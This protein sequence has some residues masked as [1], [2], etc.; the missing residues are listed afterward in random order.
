MARPFQI[1]SY[2][3]LANSYVN[4]QWYPFTDPE[5]LK[6]E[7]R[8]AALNRKIES[9]GADIICLQEVESDAYALFEY[10]LRKEGYSGIYAPKANNRPDGCATFFRQGNLRF[11]GSNTIYFNDTEEAANSGHVALILSFASGLG[12]LRVT[13]THLKWDNETKPKE[14]HAGYRQIKE[15]VDNHIKPD[16]LAHAWIVC[17]DF[18]AQ[19]GSPVIEKLLVNGFEDAYRGNEQNTCNSNRRAK[20]IDYIFHTGNLRSQPAKLRVIDNLTPLPSEVEPSDHLAIMAV[21]S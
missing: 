14:E 4:P 12:T 18:N 13:N 17:G 11:E 8:K 1:A 2:N 7:E 19:L 10:T 3:I 20:R 15:L 5:I 16:S 21:C 6:W 9:F